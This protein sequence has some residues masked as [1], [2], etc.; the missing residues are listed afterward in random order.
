M[1]MISSLNIKTALDGFSGTTRVSQAFAQ[2]QIEVTANDISIWSETFG[3]CY[4]IANKPKSYYQSIIDHLNSLSGR[5]G[6]FTQHY[7]GEEKEQKKPFQKKNTQKLDAIREEIE[8]LKLDY[9][10][11]SVILTS[12]ILALDKVDNTL[13]HFTSYLAQWS[14]RSY[15]D[16]TLHVPQKFEI[17]THNR[18]IRDDILNTVQQYEFDLAYFDPPYGSNNQK[19]PSSRVR[20]DAYYHFWKTVILNDQP[21]LFG[22]AQRREDSRDKCQPSDFDAWQQNEQGESIANKA[23]QKLLKNTQATY[24]LLSYNSTGRIDLKT[25]R[26]IIAEQ[27]KLIKQKVIDYQ[28]NIM[29]TMRWTHQ[30]S[31]NHKK[32][33]QEY[34]FLIKKK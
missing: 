14:P 28:Q 9:I 31:R 6:W 7:G 26:E 19:M 20:Y 4:L 22:K 29:A 27:G 11:E 2:N 32:R 23:L 13:G 16:L 12:L 30:W 25:L 17:T 33:H 24:I 15:K 3:Q 21:P 18:I 5:E 10:D 8:R 1:E 34:L